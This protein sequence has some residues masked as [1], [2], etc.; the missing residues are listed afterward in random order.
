VKIWLTVAALFMAL[1]VTTGQAAPPT[2]YESKAIGAALEYCLPALA[3]HTG[4]T[5][6]AQANGLPELPPVNEAL[7]LAGRKGKVFMVPGLG[8]DTVLVVPANTA[9]CSVLARQ[10]NQDAFLQAADYW[11]AGPPAPFA[12]SSDRRL[13]GGVVER[14]YQGSVGGRRLLIVVSARPKAVNGGIQG[15]ITV[16]AAQ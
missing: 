1:G 8:G 15:M 4:A 6:I 2:S 10:M 11:F 14:Q 13:A 7:F 9:A 16:G 3:T 12:K 5:Q